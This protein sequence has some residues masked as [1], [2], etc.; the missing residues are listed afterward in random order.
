MDVHAVELREANEF[1]DIPYELW[2]GPRFEKL[3]LCLSWPVTIGGYII[4]NKFESEWKDEAFLETQRK[5]VQT[6]CPKLTLHGRGVRY[7]TPW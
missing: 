2:F 7:D 5:T 6:A 4:S 3:M 1:G